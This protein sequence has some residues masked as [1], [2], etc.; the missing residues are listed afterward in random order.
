MIKRVL[1]AVCVVLAALLS[2]TA[3][4]MPAGAST[5]PGNPQVAAPCPYDGGHPEIR[6]GASGEVVRHLQCLLRNVWG[7][8]SVVIDSQFGPATNAAVVSHQRDCH[9]GVDGRVGPVTWR[10]LHPDTTTAECTDAG[11]D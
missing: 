9:I 11:R 4:A 5:P 2:T 6:Q 1:V 8:T 10:H 7:Y 3:L